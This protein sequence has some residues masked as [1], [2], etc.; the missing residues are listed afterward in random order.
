MSFD[1][2]AYRKALGCFATG[3]TIITTRD[4]AGG[5][6]GL[7]VN[8]F[9]SASMTPPLITW[10]LGDKSDSFELFSTTDS[11][12]ANVLAAS[13]GDFAMRFAG[14]GDQ[15]LADGEYETRVTGSPILPRALASFD[16]KVVDRVWLGDHL[17]LVGEVVAFSIRDGEGLTYFRSRFGVAPVIA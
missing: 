11:Y 5:A 13:D 4:S 6:H 3:V 17:M 12:A 1:V 7:T 8:S 15:S 10:C 9:T 2:Q 16:A 14:K